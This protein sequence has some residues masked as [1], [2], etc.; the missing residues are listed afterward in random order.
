M[1]LFAEIV[2]K[3]NLYFVPY[4]LKN[5]NTLDLKNPGQ[6]DRLDQNHPSKNVGKKHKLE[7]ETCNLIHSKVH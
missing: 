4:L 5:L 2:M 6:I 3:N 7:L 1:F